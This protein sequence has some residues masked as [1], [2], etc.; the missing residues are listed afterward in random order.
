MWNYPQ[1]H[2]VF[3]GLHVV[4]NLE[5]YAEKAIVEWE[6]VVEQEGG[7]HGGFKNSKNSHTYDILYEVSKLTS[8]KHGDQ[9][10]G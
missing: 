2:H 5:I 9:R 7:S 10:N 8:Y 3:C 6:K 1:M 4:H